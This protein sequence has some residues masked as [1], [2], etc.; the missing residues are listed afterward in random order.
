MRSKLYIDG[1]WVH[2]VN[3]GF[4]VVINPATEEIVQEI[5]AASEADVD[6]AV[7]A[8][9]RA[10]DKDGWPKL[11]GAERAKYLRA[12]AQG[13]RDRQEEI[14]TLEVI[15]NGKP[16]PEANWDIGDAAGC[17]DYYAGL[18]EQL[19][20]RGPENIVLS[21]DRF[22]SKAVKEPIGVAGAIIPWNYPLLMAAWKVAPAL[23]AGCTVVLKPAEVTSL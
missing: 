11:T 2:P 9:R 13:I 4:E 23:A 5:A 16:L 19:D 7:K 17:F 12:I 6:L 22:T 15:D 18:A 20:S 3:G 1:K 10:F 14:A 8:A 21:D